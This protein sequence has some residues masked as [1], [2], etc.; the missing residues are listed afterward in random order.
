MNSEEAARAMDDTADW[1]IAHVQRPRP[2]AQDAE[3]A[4]R[5]GALQQSLAH[6]RGSN[7]VAQAGAPISRADRIIAGA[8][9]GQPEIGWLRAEV[10]R[11][12]NEIENLSSPEVSPAAAACGEVWAYVDV[13]GDADL[14]NALVRCFYE[15]DDGE[16]RAVYLGRYDITPALTPSVY[17]AIDAAMNAELAVTAEEE[18]INAAI[19]RAES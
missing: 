3:I 10:R 9:F 8:S 18:N 11:L 4:D 13:R 6:Y 5:Y 16:L 17:D 15:S 19:F 12:C 2:V 14:G 1:A 7:A